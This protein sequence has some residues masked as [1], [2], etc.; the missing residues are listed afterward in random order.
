MEWK[1]AADLHRMLYATDLSA[2]SKYGIRYAIQYAS[3]HNASLIVF[4][5]I[6]QRS[7]AFS[8]IFPDFFNNAPGHNITKQ[9][10]NFALRQLER[11]L[12][13][14]S[15][16]QLYEHPEQHHT[17][18][19]LV[20]HYGK[21]AEEIAQKAHRWGCERI[22]L[23]PRRKRFLGRIFLPSVARMVRRRSN[24]PVHIIKQPKRAKL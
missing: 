10:V 20:V 14:I 4:H 22:I 23:G 24:A 18:E 17:V 21:I 7:L 13:E 12:L 3:D 16:T 11:R 19:Y 6:N 5:V 8:R 1:M 9:K 15:K 2:V